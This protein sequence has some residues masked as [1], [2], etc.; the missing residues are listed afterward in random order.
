MPPDGYTTITVPDELLDELDTYRTDD[1][2]RR[3]YSEVIRTLLDDA[4]S[5]DDELLTP[6]EFERRMKNHTDDLASTVSK[7][8]TDELESRLR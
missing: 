5:H 6:Q 1:D 8:T 4:Q 7:R 3:P 2:G